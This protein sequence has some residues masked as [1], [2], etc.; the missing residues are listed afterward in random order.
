MFYLCLWLRPTGRV[1]VLVHPTRAPFSASTYTS[2]VVFGPLLCILYTTPLSS[3]IQA[4]GH[5]LDHH[6]ILYADDT[7]IYLSF[8]APDT[9]VSLSQLSDCLQNIFHWMTDSKL[10]LNANFLNI[11]TQKQCDKL[12]CF[13]PDTYIYMLSQNFTPDD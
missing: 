12:D 5:D 4:H 6:I 1:W 8:A 2:T 13:F 7:Q 3:V 11:G 9:N 10:K